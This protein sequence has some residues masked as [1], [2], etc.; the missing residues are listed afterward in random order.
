MLEELHIKDFALID[1]IRIDFSSGLNL[2]TGETGAGKSIIL[3]ALNLVLG[4]RATT[5]MIKGG[6]R[7]AVVSGVFHIGG[8]SDLLELLEGH[9]LEEDSETLLMRR[10]ITVE[11]KGRSFINGRQVPVSL[12]K[13][14]GAHLVDIHGQNEH[15]N[16]L[17]INTHRAI[18]DR[19]AGLTGETAQYTKKFKLRGELQQKLTSVSLDEQEKNRRLEILRHEIS[20]IEGAQIENVNEMAELEAR[21]KVLDHAETLIKDLSEMHGILQGEEMG[22]LTKLSYLEKTLERDAGFDDSLSDILEPLQEAYFQ[23]SDVSSALRAKAESI[24]YSPEE[25]HTVKERLDLLQSLIRKYGPTLEDVLSYFDKASIELSGIELSSEEEAKLRSQIE[26]LTGEL[27]K[28]AKEI[29]AKR[30]EAAS[31]LEEAVQK[32]LSDLGMGS[33]KIRISMKWQYAPEGELVTPEGDKRYVLQ[34]TGVDIIEFMMESGGTLRALRKIASGG[35]MSRIMLSLKKIIA[36][37]DPVSTMIFDEVDAG[38]GGGVAEAVGQKLASLTEG[39]KRAQVMVITHLH[40]V[41]GQSAAS[42]TH[43]KVSK[44][45]AH[46]TRITRLNPEERLRELARMIGGEEITQSALDH[47]RSLLESR[48]DN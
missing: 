37:S 32:E 29:S 36:A 22:V 15:Q 2:I 33:N 48:R 30:K 6:A 17:N 41:A 34:S 39:E 16:I 46:G 45:G 24:Q 27:I 5:D 44:E 26:G 28:E 47:A 4:S 1:E 7:R 31:R 12:L 14:V 10:E 9:G 19:Y 21:E 25:V 11:G 23:L 3:G 43:F 38:V 13:S 35:E 8:D 40:Q 20:E 18:L 42:T